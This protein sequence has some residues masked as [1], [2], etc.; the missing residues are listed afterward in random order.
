MLILFMKSGLNLEFSIFSVHLIPYKKVY[1]VI[2][3]VQQ[4][5]QKSYSKF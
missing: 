2:T 4:T 3:S 1:D 5:E